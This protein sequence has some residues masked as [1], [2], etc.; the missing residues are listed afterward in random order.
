LDY[1]HPCV[2]LLDDDPSVQKII[3]R[4]TQQKV[5][6]LHNS[7]ELTSALDADFEPIISFVDVHLDN[8]ENGLDCIPSLKQKWPYRPIIVVTSDSNE[9]IVAEALS[10]GADDF[11]YKP[12]HPKE[13]LARMQIRLEELG[14]REFRENIVFGD[15][16]L[17]IA[18]KT[19][20]KDKQKIFISPIEL[21]VLL[22][23][24]SAHSTIV[25]RQ[26]LKRKCW[27]EINVS[28]NALNRKLYETRK[29]LTDLKSKVTIK[30][31]YG[32]GFAIK[33]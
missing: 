14:K 20:T 31:I 26:A 11:I 2:L 8:S 4:T 23:L 13:L 5:L 9:S 32:S 33:E 18:Q 29:L 16:T 30:T 12:I 21:N 28:D 6:S 15:I 19:I 25:P 7:K 27:A 24:I 1:E 3:E 17:N 22:T 10:S